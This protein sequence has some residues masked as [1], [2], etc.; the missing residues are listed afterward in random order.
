MRKKI[1]LLASFLL[2][3]FMTMNAQDY[4]PINGYVT[5][6]ISGDPIVSHEVNILVNDSTNYYSW[7]VLTDQTGFYADTIYQTGYNISS[8]SIST[9]DNCSYLYHDTTI[10]N[11]VIG[12]PI[13]AD[14]EIC[15]DSTT[16]DCQADFYY[17]SDSSNTSTVY[18]YDQSTPAG[19]INSWFWNFGDGTSSSEQNPTHLFNNGTYNVCLTIQTIQGPNGSCTSTTCMDVYVSGGSGGDCMANFYYALNN[20]NSDSNVVSFIDTSIPFGNIEFW[21]WDFGDGT[22]SSDQ[23][24]IHIYAQPGNYNVCLTIN[25]FQGSGGSCTSTTCQDVYVSSGSGGDCQADFYYIADSSNTN[26]IDFIDMSIPTGN[27]DS[28]FWNFGDGSASS[29][30]NPTHIFNDGTYYVCLT[31]T[32]DSCTS[33]FC[34]NVQVGGSGGDC[35]A[36]FSYYPDSSDLYMIYFIDQ[37]MPVGCITSWFW[38]FG[39]GIAS[40]DQN[41]VH[42]YNSSGIYNVCLTIEAYT[43]NNQCTSTY[44]V[45]VI[46]QGGTN[47]YYLG[48][49]TFA[50]NY[51]LDLGFAYAYK[52]ENGTISDVYSQMIDTLGY[53]LFYPFDE[54]F[55][56]TKV[57]PTPGSAYFSDYLPTFYGDVVH[58][59]DAVLISLNENIF[60]ADINLVGMAQSNPGTGLIKGQIMYQGGSRDNTPANNIQ[61]MLANNEGQ[62]VGMIYSN[63]DGIFEFESLSNGTYTLY[64]EI[65]GKSIIPK[66]F[67]LSNENP[68]V[69]DI[70][71]IITETGITFGIDDVQSKYIENISDIYPNPVISTLKI[72]IVLKESS[73]IECNII[74]LTGQYLNRQIFDLSY[75]NTIELR[76]GEL[77]P[78]MYILEIITADAYKFSKRFVKY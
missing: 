12:V 5:N 18:F 33:T 17:V 37:S 15:D 36:G 75:S 28:W 8:V 30:Q 42:T 27:I 40:S 73:Q 67:V 7:T 53:Y 44:C 1:I 39:D 19:S 21:S 25:T 54:G 13:I 63:E 43:G 71:M 55:Y 51:Q 47:T 23:N 69:E 41:P 4:I 60:N 2:L 62:Y 76:T 66:N 61:I 20:Y 14:F 6:E 52:S 10:N 50:G 48:G 59:E 57:E 65:M 77:N 29:E 24:P 74:S 35:Q 26:S 34:M 3:G 49:N 70:L 78:G 38:E 72:D 11:P 22:T 45:N 64:A 32:S 9:I 46:V 58:W 31:I 56:Y 16:N 68:V